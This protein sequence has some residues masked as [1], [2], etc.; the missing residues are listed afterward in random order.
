MLP[1]GTCR[2]LRDSPACGWPLATPDR[3]GLG[4]M[5]PSVGSATGARLGARSW[6]GHQSGPPSVT[7]TTPTNRI[8]AG[9]RLTKARSA[10]RSLAES[11]KCALRLGLDRDRESAADT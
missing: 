9:A 6:L 8:I 5:S 10:G 3:C 1:A 2:S 11:G 4:Q 7:P